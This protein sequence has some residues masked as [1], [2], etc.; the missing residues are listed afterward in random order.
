MLKRAICI[1]NPFE[2]GGGAE[3][4]ISLLIDELTASG[5]E[6]HYLAHF[7]DARSPV[8]NYRAVKIG[9]GDSPPK[10]GYIMDA[11]SLYRTLSGIG[12]TAI[13]QRVA[14][15]YTGV[16]AA[17]SR[18]RAI[19][20]I[21]HAA[22]DAEVSGQTLD[23]ARNRVRVWLERRT[24]A[25]G[26]RHATRIVV[27]T[28][29]QAALLHETFGRSADAVIGNFHPPA[30]EDADKRGPTTVLWI[31]NLKP[32]KR[33]E[34]FVRLARA[35]EDC[36]DVRFVMVGAPAPASGNEGWQ[37]ELMRNI[38]AAAN[39]RFLGHR[40]QDEVN[41]LLARSHLF[42]NTST[43]E[44]FPNTFIQSWLRDVAVVSLQVDPDGVLARERVG[45]AAGTEQKLIAAVRALIEDPAER[46][47][48]AARGREHALRHHS[49]R[50]AGELM[51][52]IDPA[53]G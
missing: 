16:C 48:L 47:A 6:V 35:L 26:I 34:V 2:H 24:T 51:R 9:S 27:Q 4:Q 40:T 14:C 52:V 10:M 21:W 11:P 44:G 38:G 33:P 25:Y 5:Y 3:Y 1:V 41:A 15:A 50:N 37:N 53:G 19:P 36:R 32:W 18:R 29:H 31:A 46:A 13:Y 12:P 28:R 45:I 23:A 8:R 42:V 7:L 17:Y 39:L 20:L 43:Q 49:L 22:H 30:A